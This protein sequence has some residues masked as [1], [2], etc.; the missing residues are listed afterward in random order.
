MSLSVGAQIRTK[1]WT[2]AMIAYNW[3]QLE[4]GGID[5]L[6]YLSDLFDQPAKCSDLLRDLADS[7]THNMFQPQFATW[8]VYMY[9]KDIFF[10]S[11]CGC[12]SFLPG[13]RL[14]LTKKSVNKGLASSAGRSTED[15]TSLGRSKK[16]KKKKKKRT[17]TEYAWTVFNKETGVDLDWKIDRGDQVFQKNVTQ[18][19]PQTGLQFNWRKNNRYILNDK[20]TY[21]H[22]SL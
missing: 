2:F 22:T 4:T 12:I 15:W 11:E 13:S 21:S 20:R 16:K 7:L 18:G 6:R 9:T 5:N 8:S 17:N 19:C 1:L 3:P 10:A 14:T